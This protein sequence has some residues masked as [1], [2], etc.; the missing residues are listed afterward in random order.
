VN[1]TRL[2]AESRHEVGSLFYTHMD[3]TD[4][5]YR[6]DSEF[7]VRGMGRNEDEFFRA[8]GS[9]VSTIWHAPWYVIS[10]SILD[11]TRRMNYVYVGRDVDPLDW[12][13]LDGSGAM[14]SLYRR[15]PDLVE[16]LL[17][18]V[19]PGSVIPIRIGKPGKRDDYFFRKI[20]LLINGLLNDGY[21]IVSVG[22]LMES[23]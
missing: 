15:S 23:N 8:T 16:K 12:V 22:E 21:H 18:E 7:V 17:E 4:F 14:G 19:R 20:D 3:M 10:P 1:P 2:L 13:V 6:I 11:A 9:E 5:R